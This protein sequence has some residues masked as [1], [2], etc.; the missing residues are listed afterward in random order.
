MVESEKKYKELSALLQ[1]EDPLLVLR[2]V[3]LLRDEEPFEG[4]IG[5]L[6]DAYDRNNA[7]TVMKAIEN[8]MNDMKDRSLQREMVKEIKKERK[9]S[10]TGMLVASCWQSGLDYSEFYLDFTEI[11]L[12]SDYSVALECLTVLEE[13]SPFLKPSARKEMMSMIGR[14]PLKTSDPKKPLLD[15]LIS[16]LGE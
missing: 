11:F 6:A 14:Y 3:E 2:T 1:K 16:V 5:L 10:T 9:S 8:F 4:A 13:A 12:S 15:Q 7:P